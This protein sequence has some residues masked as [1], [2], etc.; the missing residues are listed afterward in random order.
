MA[1]AQRTADHGACDGLLQILQYTMIIKETL[2]CNNNEIN[3][4]LI[5]SEVVVTGPRNH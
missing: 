1:F 4:V 5:I 3:M 2:K